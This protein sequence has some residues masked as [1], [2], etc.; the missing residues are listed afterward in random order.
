MSRQSERQIYEMHAQVCSVLSN[1]K[2]LEII[3]LLRENEKTVGDLAEKMGLA[4]ANVSQQIAILRHKGLLLARREGQHIYYR[5]AYPKMLK[6]YDLL[7]E[8]LMERL[9]KQGEWFEK[10]RKEG[11]TK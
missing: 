2:R 8:I 5:L 1:P 4:K 6:A 3:N 7:R 10:L 11:E 9:S